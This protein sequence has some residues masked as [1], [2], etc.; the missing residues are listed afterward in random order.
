V[1]ANVAH[2]EPKGYLSFDD[3]FYAPESLAQKGI[4]TTTREEYRP[5]DARLRLPYSA[6]KLIDRTGGL[7]VKTQRLASVTQEFSVRARTETRAEF[8]TFA[9]PGWKATIDGKDTPLSIVP[10][11]GTQQITIPAG[12]HMVRLTLH[13]TPVRLWSA[14]FSFLT[15]LFAVG[16]AVV[17]RARELRAAELNV[18]VNAPEVDFNARP[19]A[20]A[21][22]IFAAGKQADRS[23]P[24][25]TES[26]LPSA[27]KKAHGK[28]VAGEHSRRAKRAKRSR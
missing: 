26:T 10:G 19:R 13:S 21:S 14:I 18:R 12:E 8:A 27:A 2:T 6:S 23:T 25:A 3:E 9:Y 7:E 28:A 4:N 11:R 20:S 1:I 24:S 22:G 5:R 17:A 16:L 15:A